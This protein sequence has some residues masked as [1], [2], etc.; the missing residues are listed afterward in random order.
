[1]A[2]L[3]MIKAITAAMD[4][5]LARDEKV[6]IFGE[7]VG[8]N[9][10]VFRATDGL[11]AKYGKDRVFDTPLAE[12]GIMGLANGLALTG[13]RPV[14][15]IQFM[16]FIYEAFDQI[17]G[18]MARYRFRMGGS[19]EFPITLRTPYGGGVH[20]PE[21]HSD[22]LEGLVAQI[23]GLR[24]VTPSGPYDAKGL[25]ISAIR[26]NDPV[27]FLEHMKLYR[28]M[29][30]EVS[31]D[32][33]TVPLDKAEVK[34]DGT[35]VTIISYAYMLQA[36]LQA[37]KDLEKQGIHA[38]VLDLRTLA[39]LDEDSILASVKKTGRVVI[40]QEAQ[41][42]AGVANQVSRLIGEKGILYLDAPI[43]VVAAPDTP[44]P[45]S[46]GEDPWLPNKKDIEQAVLDTVNF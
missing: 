43:K 23:P 34:K 33:Y 8:K 14:P 28:S 42:Q 27:V 16:G 21:L 18:Q 38:E 35:D 4:E 32:A 39:P 45:F 15:E 46:Q 10:G 6:Q 5:E 9:G 7:D 41:K 12:S 20:T 3:T 17:A 1:M 37:A 26:S 30:E 24:V 2:K 22:S 29:R 36:S 11:Q 19:R 40:V 25:L 31:D 44:Y 13:F